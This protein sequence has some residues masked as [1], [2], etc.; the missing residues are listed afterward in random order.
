[1]NLFSIILIAFVGVVI[2]V[3]MGYLLARR[4]IK[5]EKEETAKE[6]VKDSRGI[7]R[8]NIVE[9]L[10]PLIPE[11]PGKFSEVRHIGK[12][13]DFLVFTGMDESNITEIGF[14]DVKT[15]KSPLTKNER[16]VKEII[17]DAQKKGAKVRWETYKPDK[18]LA[19]A[20]STHDGTHN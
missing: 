19:A 16:S 3:V 1:M 10:A 8:G 18:E 11:F 12:P 13:I 7:T 4:K 17:I 15:G 14:I 9:E 2:G 6:A 20:N 5:E